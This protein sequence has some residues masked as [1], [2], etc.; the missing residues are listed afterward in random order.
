MSDHHTETSRLVLVAI[1]FA[2]A[3]G[4][5]AVAA[6]DKPLRLDL[7]GQWSI[8]LDPEGVGEEQRWFEES[9]DEQKVSLPGTTDLAGLGSPLDLETMT[10]PVEFPDST[11]PSGGAFGKVDEWGHL[12]RSVV[13]LGKAWYQRPID[14]PE[15][16]S[17]RPARLVLE[18]VIWRTK[19]W[20]D[21]RFIGA[22]DSLVAAHR[23]DLGVLTPGRHRL[24]VCVDNGMAHNIGLAGH[25]YGP[26]TQS[27]WNG[28]VGDIELVA[29]DPV[30]LRRLEIFPAADHTSVM[31]RAH[32]VN[33][34]DRAAKT[35]LSFEV[36]SESDSEPIG[37]VV[38]KTTVDPGE[39][40]IEGTIAIA[41]P[42]RS[43]NEFD[44]ALYVV[45]AILGS[46][47]TS[48]ET[49]A[50][51]GFR[52]I[53]RD[54][55]HILVDGQR[56]FLRGTLDCCVYP[57]TG[58]PPMTVAG[59]SK[60]FETVR[61]YGFNHVRFHTWCPP[62]AA[63]EAADR[64][65]LYL[66][67]ETPFWVDGW[68][69][70]LG[71]KPA[72]LGADAEVTEYVRRE[73]R[74]IS[75][76]YGNHPSFAFFCIGN[77]FGGGTD[78]NLV[79]DLLVE[80]KERDPR[81]LYNAATA[82]RRVPA[83]DYLVT[84]NTG[85][86]TRGVGPDH[87]AWNFDTAAMAVDLPVV[88]HETGQRPVFPDYDVL[89][90]KFG[91]PLQPHDLVRFERQLDQ[92]GMVDQIDDFV[93]AS[94][95]FQQVQYRAEHEAIRRTE[96]YAGYQLLML[97]DFTGQ[98]EALVGMLDPFLESKRV[99]RAEEVRRWNAPT[100][101]LARFDRHVWTDDREF[102]AAV[103]VSHFGR[104]RLDESTAHWSLVTYDGT[105]V[106]GGALGPVDVDPGGLTPFGRIV[107]PLGGLTEP[108]Q[109][110][111][112]VSVGPVVNA[113]THW[114]Y[115]TGGNDTDQG[116]ILFA[117][118]FDAD[119]ERALADGR[120]VLLQV[121]GLENRYAAR[122]GFLS[123]YWSAGWWGNEF[124]SLGILC[125]PGHPA[126]AL[127]PNQGHSD[128]QWF[129]L[130]EGATTLLLDETPNGLM[131]IVQPV[132]DFHYN[133]KLSHLFEARVG[134]GRLLVCGYDLETDLDGRRAARQFR[135]SLLAYANSARFEPEHE[136]DPTF[137]RRLLRPPPAAPS[138][139]AADVPFDD[140]SLHV[141]AASRLEQ[142]GM[143]TAWS[144]AL[145]EA[146]RVTPG[147]DW[148]VTSG[149]TWR[150]ESGTAWHG[151]P[152]GLEIEV[153]TGTSGILFLHVHDWNGLNRQGKVSVEGREYR[154]GH[155][156]GDGLW[157][158]FAITRLD[159]GD[160]RID[161]TAEPTSGPNLMIT[162]LLFSANP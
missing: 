126:L 41:T 161:I 149:G 73:M 14:V 119:V 60:V 23:F 96:D 102:S 56:I 150:D 116:N 83:D 142:R 74:R 118:S 71:S 25:A 108:V 59:W 17:G 85:R 76:E 42:V 37:T 151:K 132:P 53:E 92:N 91:G 3:F 114:C 5:P 2:T 40:R 6:E 70:E 69:A 117:K 103:E 52:T 51:F 101:V 131:P 129:E 28:I 153:P 106:A 29:A 32:V 7:S 82:R 138:V 87:T 81:R 154:L 100:V 64:L 86:S 135:R 127:F 94:A 77:E 75:E 133:R 20:I 72:L 31:V 130:T 19:V 30:F 39:S 49:T 48:K 141:K 4:R 137:L 134:P 18:R 45:S 8:R 162:D 80:A 34:T 54:G 95:R 79:N 36:T 128:W 109:M 97:G 78:W 144:R 43:W 112:R 27:R 122:T 145:D 50:T 66:A 21:D 98:S 93:R 90:P 113:W 44:P 152:L 62:E 67:P 157:L 22:D 35:S 16:W 124:S 115:P 1:L 146:V 105:V 121:H 139:P 11:F 24:T 47:S 46:L 61:E 99:V 58:H 15:H 57:R 159:S 84:H 123:V 33:T 68:T 38:V 147:F 55:R 107:A 158:A 111:L 65:G 155:H 13:H 88:V 160:G 12:S 89:L 120:N 143:N 125:D 104:E 148:R 9:T 63:F 110:T 156:T 140:A 26:E 10:Y 136:L